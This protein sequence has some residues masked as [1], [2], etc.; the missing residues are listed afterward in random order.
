M[1]LIP[2]EQLEINELQKEIEKYYEINE[3]GDI[4]GLAKHLLIAGYKKQDE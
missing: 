3:L 2:K 1:S 4:R